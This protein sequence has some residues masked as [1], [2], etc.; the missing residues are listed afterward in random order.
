MQVQRPSLSQEQR[1]KMNPQLYQSIK[2][3]ELPIVDLRERIE[4]EVER[5]PALEVLED[6]LTVSLDEAYAPQK[7]EDTYFEE[8]SDPG[9]IRKGGD[10]DADEQNK[11]IEG[12]LSRPETL[13][14]HLLWQLRLQPVDDAIRRIGERLIQNLNADGF[15]E[16]PLPALL[17]G[18]DP[19]AVEAALSL[20]RSLDPQGTCT[21]DYR[22]SLRVQ[23]KLL[24]EAPPGLEDALE[25]LELLERG[26]LA[27]LGKKIN[28]TED[29]V[30]LIADRIKELSPFPGRQFSTEDTRYVVPDVQ[31]IRKEG[32]FVIVL[33]EE[34]IPVLG[35]NPFF[36][37]I[38]GGK[39]EEKTAR[40]FARENIK[41]ARWFIQSI[42]QRNHTLLR[43]SRAIVEFQRSFFA[44]GPKYLAPLTLKDIA[45]E[46]GVHETTVSRTANGKYMQTEWGIFEIKHFFTNSISGAGSGGSRY[47][48]EGVKEIIR[49]LIQSE[50]RNF[51]DQELSDLLA[52]KGIP[53]A[54]RTVA[55]Y[56]KELDF[57]SSYT[58]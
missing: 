53:L 47:S 46:L 51:S 28:R 16:E 1:L 13:Q 43:V 42:N 54:R 31:V 17:K 56:R 12:A 33:N 58:R 44:N 48:K 23:A 24:P 41:E 4:E 36:M 2:L 40:D 26:K 29:E 50:A 32:E 15:N 34:E 49:E 10:S 3:M 21:A 18:K 30:R 52:Q 35:I 37:K 6:R 8:S 55:K 22:E 19:A 14:E 11:F 45:Q 5:N 20:V 25:Y 9:F 57:G 27:E 39:E 7:D 38:S